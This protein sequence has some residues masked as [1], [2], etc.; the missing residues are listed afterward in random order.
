MATITN[1]AVIVEYLHRRIKKTL[2]GRQNK[3]NGRE[4][5]HSFVEHD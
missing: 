1:A 5:F 3:S 4:S 2:I